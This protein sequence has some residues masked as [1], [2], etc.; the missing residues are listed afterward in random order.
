MKVRE[1]QCQNPKILPIPAIPEPSMAT[2]R[3]T[4]KWMTEFLSP[5]PDLI[6]DCNCPL[7]DIEEY[8]KRD[9]SGFNT[10]PA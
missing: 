4:M 2:N 8:R 7:R 9:A 10:T 5:M 3:L 1:W 6:Y